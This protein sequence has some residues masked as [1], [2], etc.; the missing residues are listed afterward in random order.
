[1]TVGADEIAFRELLPEQPRAAKSREVRKIIHLR[2]AWAMIE[3]HGDGMK[4]STAIDARLELEVAHPRDEVPLT[5]VTLK[6][7]HVAR[8]RVVRR[9]VYA[10]TRLAPQLVAVTAAVEV[11]HR[12]QNA[13][14]RAAP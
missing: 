13:A 5:C 14:E 12:L 9:V 10:T 11:R 4:A 8:G 7:T 1:V 3:C 6:P 2:S